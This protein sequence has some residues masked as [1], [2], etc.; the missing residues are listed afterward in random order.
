VR[1]RR[2]RGV[3]RRSRPRAVPRLPVGLAL[4][5]AVIAVPLASGSPGPSAPDV[6]APQQLTVQ[7]GRSTTGEHVRLLGPGPV[8]ASFAVPDRPTAGGLWLAVQFGDAAGTSY[9]ARAHVL[10]TGAV[11]VEVTTD[12][13]CTEHLLAERRTA[14]VVPE[15][16]GV[17]TVEGFLD[18]GTGTLLRLGVR[19]W[20][21]VTPPSSWLYARAAPRP[22]TAPAPAPGPAAGTTE[23]PRLPPPGVAA[24][25]A[26]AWSYLSRLSARPMRIRYSGPATAGAALPAPDAD[27]VPLAVAAATR[28]EQVSAAS[29]ADPCARYTPPA[30]AVVVAPGGDD[31]GSGTLDSPLATIAAAVARAPSGGTVVLRG[32]VYRQD[33]GSVGKPLTFQPYL[34]E[35][36]VL[37]GADVVTDWTRQGTAWATTTWRS[38]FGQ[39]DFRQEEVPPGSP[40]GHVE[41][42][43]RDG[44]PLRR[45]LDRSALLPGC[46]WVDPVT[47]RLWVADD[48]ATA[49]LELSSRARGMTLERAA[50]GSRVLGLRFTA[51]AAPHLDDTGE[52]FVNGAEGTL[53]ENSTFDHSSGAGLKISG[54]RM[55]VRRSTIRDNAGEGMQGNRTDDAVVTGNLFLRNNTAGFK[56]WD[57][58]ASCTVAGYKAAHTKRLTVTDNAFVDNAS[59]GFWC[60]LGCTGAV[61]RGNVVRGGYDGIFYEVSSGGLIEDNVVSGADKGIR[62]SGSDRVS[63]EGN[64]LVDNTWQLTVLDDRRSPAADRYSSAQGLTWDVSDLVVERNV[65][66][67]GPRTAKVLQVNATSQVLPAQ[68]FR[69]VRGNLVEGPQVLAWCDR[70][71]SCRDLH[72]VA[73]WSR[74]SGQPFS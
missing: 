26:S 5:A 69:S 14:A 2:W 20:T 7:P 1:R 16:G 30:G 56:V 68:M 47:L 21:D 41:Q 64:T 13:G 28:I 52:L 17:L 65:L 22:A 40:A 70:V 67:G 49:T 63:V 18:P 74:A 61:V 36:P 25:V 58:G 33:A 55:V 39:H 19:A 38:P 32:G 4:L 42:A 59:N 71:G 53:I 31:R 48:P 37:S 62:V 43:Y 34:D 45:V 3:I 24:Q 60:D 6:V 66:L 73:A 11:S 23:Q 51:Y 57:C 54:P 12:D 10:P 46:F 50:A 27:V 44:V 8:R 29:G 9:R 15:Q 35:H 72:S